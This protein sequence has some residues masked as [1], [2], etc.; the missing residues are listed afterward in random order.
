MGASEEERTTPPGDRGGRKAVAEMMGDF[1]REAAVLV[2]VFGWLDKAVRSEPF[3]A[4][5][6]GWNVFALSSALFFVGAFLE[7]RRGPA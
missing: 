6:W 5:S 7:R 1:F 2:A 4:E 3:V